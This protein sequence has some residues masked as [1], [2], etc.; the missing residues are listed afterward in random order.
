[1]HNLSRLDMELLKKIDGQPGLTIKEVIDPFL[2]SRSKRTLYYK[3]LTL[4][5]HGLVRLDRTTMSRKV[6]CYPTAETRKMLG[7][8]AE[9]LDTAESEAL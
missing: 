8:T 5:A 4:E 2:K 1:M 3:I 7:A 6:L 9:H